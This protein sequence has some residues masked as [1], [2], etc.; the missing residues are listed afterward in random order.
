[1][2]GRCHAPPGFEGLHGGRYEHDLVEAEHVHDLGGCD[3]VA[4]V[5]RVEGTAHDANRPTPAQGARRVLGQRRG[6]GHT[7]GRFRGLFDRFCAR[8][9]GQF[10]LLRAHERMVPSPS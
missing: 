4:V 5:D 2:F 3:E 8:G 7:R 6:G 1:M 10:V 9:L